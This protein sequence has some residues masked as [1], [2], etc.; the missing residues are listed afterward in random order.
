MEKKNVFGF[1]ILGCILFL[2]HM[3]IEYMV[4]NQILL[5]IGIV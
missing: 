3:L 5:A 4:I 1:F 2:A